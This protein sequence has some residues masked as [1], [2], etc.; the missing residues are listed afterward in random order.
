M[1]DWLYLKLVVE[2]LGAITK[3]VLGNYE[4]WDK[5]IDKMFYE[6]NDK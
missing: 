4:E 2:N 5:L 3:A 1:G 6:Y